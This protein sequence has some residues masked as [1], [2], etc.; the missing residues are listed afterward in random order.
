MKKLLLLALLLAPS[1][2]KAVDAPTVAGPV[3][4]TATDNELATPFANAYRQGFVVSVTSITG[5]VQLNME[6]RLTSA[7]SWVALPLTEQSSGARLTGGIVANGT[8]LGSGGGYRYF[9]AH[10]T[11]VS[12]GVARVVV[13]WGDG[14]NASSLL[15]L[16]VAKAAV[17]VSTAAAT[18][19]YTPTS[20]KALFLK[21]IVLYISPGLSSATP[22]NLMTFFEG[23]TTI[24]ATPIY[25]PAVALT[26]VPG[27]QVVTVDLGAGRLFGTINVPLTATLTGD[28]TGSGKIYVAPIVAEK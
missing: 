13:S 11:S 23:A 24:T 19:I 16:T 6:G 28:L 22:N 3:T 25:S 18:T 7:E 4:F 27:V 1:L 21:R 20:G 2:V 26:S 15:D 8:Y 17:S 9:R 14:D 5:T 10:A 12:S